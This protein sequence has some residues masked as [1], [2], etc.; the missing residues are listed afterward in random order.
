MFLTFV[1]AKKAQSESKKKKKELM[2][3]TRILSYG[4]RPIVDNDVIEWA[5]DVDFQPLP[6]EYDVVSIDNLFNERI[7]R[8]TFSK[9]RLR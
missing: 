5:S 2:Q 7:Y 6:V 4:A 3:D 9:E 1:T 8:K